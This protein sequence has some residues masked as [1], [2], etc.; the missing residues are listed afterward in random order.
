MPAARGGG[1][2]D[3]PGA[4]D[5]LLRDCEGLA[6]RLSEAI[7]LRYFSHVYEPARATAVI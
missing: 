6:L 4:L 1:L 2:P 5:G 7:T 3:D